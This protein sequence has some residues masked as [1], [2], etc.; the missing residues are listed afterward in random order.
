MAD[1][2]G[3]DEGDERQGDWTPP[4]NDEEEDDDGLIPA[5][6]ARAST[7]SSINTDLFQAAKKSH[8]LDI[9]NNAAGSSQADDTGAHRGHGA[10]AQEEH[11]TPNPE[12]GKVDSNLIAK[13]PG[14]KHTHFF[15]SC[16]SSSSSFSNY[17]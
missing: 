4:P 8:D 10:G 12:A 13:P 14:G 1:D 9:G 16:F 2:D 3:G 6:S 5:G 15:I 7:R 11:G 17:T